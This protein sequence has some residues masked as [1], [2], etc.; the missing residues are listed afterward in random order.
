MTNYGE[1]PTIPGCTAH[2]STFNPLCPC[3]SDMKLKQ[4]MEVR[5]DHPIYLDS[6]ATHPVAEEAKDAINEVYKT[7]GTASAAVI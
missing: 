2:N 1:Q 7:V 6:A 4:I 5:I 3:P